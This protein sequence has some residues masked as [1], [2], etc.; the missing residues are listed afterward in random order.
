MKHAR[1]GWIVVLA[2]LLCGASARAKD[3][4]AAQAPPAGQDPAAATQAPAS[5]QGLDRAG[6][7]K[8]REAAAIAG[9]NGTIWEIELTP[10][11]GE[12]GKR[13]VKETLR[14]DQGKVTAER[15]ASEGYPASN[16]TLTIGN[17]EIPV[18]ETMQTGEGKGV[19]FWRGEL[20]GQTLSGVLSKHPVEGTTEDYSFVG[21]AATGSA[22]PVMPAP[23]SQAPA[24]QGGATT[25]APKVAATPAA[26]VTP[27]PAA[28][29]TLQSAPKKKGWW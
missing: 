19:V 28:A 18:W 23:S 17:D 22:A 2:V 4:P 8:A 25:P 24:A 5:A 1:F 11:S 20:H 6:A 16:F 3:E 15:L 29:S 13:P 12:P 26:P 10:M 7:K 14:F 21:H 9:L 27:A